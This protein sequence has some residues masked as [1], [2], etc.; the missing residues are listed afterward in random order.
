ME[1]SAEW[2]SIDSNDLGVVYG[3]FLYGVVMFPS[4]AFALVADKVENRAC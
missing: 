3:K 2:Q 4:G 1:E